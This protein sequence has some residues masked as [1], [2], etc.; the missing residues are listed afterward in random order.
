[1][2]KTLLM[3][4]LAGLL[5]SGCASIMSGRTQTINVQSTSEDDV[6]IEVV[7]KS[8]V[9]KVK[10]PAVISVKRSKE[11]IQLTVKDKCFR[12]QSTSIDSGINMWFLGNIITGGLTGTSTDL[13]TGAI[14]EYDE[15]ILVPAEKN[16]SC[17]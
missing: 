14:W 1:M 9:Q 6:V 10:T 13:I 5:L 3:L 17:K 16:A 7:S 4:P 12:R 15:T 8:G 2:K 11:S